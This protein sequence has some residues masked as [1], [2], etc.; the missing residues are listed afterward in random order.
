MRYL[1]VIGAVLLLAEQ[2]PGQDVF[3]G[4]SVLP[5]QQQTGETIPQ[6]IPSVQNLPAGEMADPSLS[7]EEAGGAESGAITNAVDTAQVSFLIDTGVQY[8][9]EGEYAEAERA[10][11][12]AL[13]S[14]PGDLNI[15]FRLSTLYIQMKQYARAADL[16]KKLHEVAPDNVGVCNNLAWIYATGD[17][18]KNGK[19]ALRYAREALLDNPGLPPV[20]NTLAE[21]YYVSGDYDAA[22]RS[23]DLAVELL[24][25][26]N[27]T[28]ET[29][30]SFK[31]Q[32][33]K[34]QRA[35]EAYK[36]FQGTDEEQ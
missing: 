32:R 25:K 35:I 33:E 13:E 24:K 36:R 6:L 11:L 23:S 21:A 20:W 1:F 12:R 14:A 30:A 26:T 29:L 2:S 17:E 16:L 27:P 15:R 7:S 9:D 10:Y 3:P 8:E 31:E 19:L 4:S 22:L 5:P 34:I 18:I 28:Q